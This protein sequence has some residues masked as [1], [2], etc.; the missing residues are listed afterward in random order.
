MQIADIKELLNRCRRAA[1]LKEIVAFDFCVDETRCARLRL[2]NGKIHLVGADILPPLQAVE[3]GAN[4]VA[5]HPISLPK[6]MVCRH[7]AFCLQSKEAIVKLLNFPGH[8]EAGAEAKIRED[9][10]IG[11][12]EYRIGYKILGY[13]HTRVETKLLAVAFPEKIILGY[14]RHFSV[15]W[16]VPVSVEV[17]GLAAIN[18]FINSYLETCTDESI[19]VVQFEDDL[20]FFAFFHRKELVLIRKYEFGYN[21]IL[22]EIQR[23]L[24][25]N[26][27]TALNVVSDHSFD[28]SQM[29]REVCDSFVRQIVISKHFVERRENCRVARIFIP[30]SVVASQRIA[31]EIRV[32]SEVEIEQWDPL[33]ALVYQPD[34]LTAKLAGRSYVFA[35][36]IGAGIGYFGEKTG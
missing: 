31:Q 36:L 13:S 1:G 32:A 22:S 18:V 28:I 30:S 2:S 7:A 15:G 11:E 35:A 4:K 29:I 23:R 34:M 26:R 25:V 14:L 16:P 8:F 20:S 10:G 12:G 19:G 27:E 24:N 6:N 5:T 3:G 33:K 17:A 9:I 21:N